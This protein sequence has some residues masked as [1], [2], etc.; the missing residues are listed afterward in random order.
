MENEGVRLFPTVQAQWLL[1]ASG[2]ENTDT[3]VVSRRLI[4]H[5]S[6][7][8]LHG[9]KRA[10]SPP[11]LS[12]RG[13]L[14]P[15]LWTSAGP[16]VLGQWN[17]GVIHSATSS[18][19]SGAVAWLCHS[20]PSVLGSWVVQ[21]EGPPPSRTPEWGRHRASNLQLT[22]NVGKKQIFLVL[23]SQ[24]ILW[25]CLLLQHH[26][27]EL[28]DTRLTLQGQILM[29]DMLALHLIAL[30]PVDKPPSPSWVSA[31]PSKHWVCT[32]GTNLCPRNGFL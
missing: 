19:S 10:P 26:C 31:I 22:C 18:R 25:G 21:V 20:S 9:Y 2:A 13:L 14:L 5:G 7:V 3:V 23:T 6:H 1:G 27:T 32:S 12:A 15:A 8:R 4:S 16:D 24:L 17:V 11:L 28:T 29:L 30:W